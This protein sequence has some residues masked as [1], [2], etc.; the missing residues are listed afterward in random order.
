MM[1]RNGSNSV[2]SPKT[3]CQS[4]MP[5]GNF[6]RDL[7]VPSHAATRLPI[8]VVFQ[9]QGAPPLLVTNNIVYAATH[10]SFLK[11][12]KNKR[13]PCGCLRKNQILTSYGGIIRIRFKGRSLKNFLSACTTSAPVVVA[14]ITKPRRMSSSW[15]ECFL[16]AKSP[17]KQ[18]VP[19]WAFSRTLARLANEKMLIT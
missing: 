1:Q 9:T 2:V 7:T 18:L 11:A 19:G 10:T 4:K 16:I 6:G 13:H 15:C 12:S 14:I 5:A 8:A 17:A 3:N